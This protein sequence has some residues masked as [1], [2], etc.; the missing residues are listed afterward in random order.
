MTIGLGLCAFGFG[1]I[2]GV[3]VATVVGSGPVP[4]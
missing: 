3:I 4:R 2:W 1:F